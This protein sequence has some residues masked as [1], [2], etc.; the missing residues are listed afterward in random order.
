MSATDTDPL[1]ALEDAARTATTAA[2]SATVSIGRDGRGSGVV[3]S[4]GSVL[5]NAHN[6]RDRTT[7]VTFPDGRVGQAEV[8]GVD[9]AGDLAVLRVDTAGATPIEWSDTEPA[10]G[11]VVF[12]ASAGRRGSRVSL[13]M[14]SGTGRSFRGPRGRWISGSL[15]HTAPLARGSSGGPLVDR[16]GRLVGVNT[17]RLGEGFYLAVAADESLRQR[18]DALAAGRSP[19]TLTLGVAIAPPHVARRLRASVGLPERDGLLVRGI[20]PDG[21]ADR[22]GVREGDLIVAAGGAPTPTADAL[23]DVLSSHDATTALDLH[24]VR[25]ADEVQLSVTFAERDAGAPAGDDVEGAPPE[26]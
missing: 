16:R 25:G 18:V 19:S 21:P 14:I 11:A 20:E 22:A 15:E 5:T 3:I 2:R 13:G 23:F 8:A 10:E 17:H 26:D 4:E 12:G 1:T 6:L 7:S 24:V 9:P